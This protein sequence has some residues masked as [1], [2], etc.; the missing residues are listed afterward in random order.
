MK[1]LLFVFG[2]VFLLAGCAAP[3]KVETH[4]PLISSIPPQYFEAVYADLVIAEAFVEHGEYLWAYLQYRKIFAET[5]DEVAFFYYLA[6]AAAEQAGS[7]HVV[8][9]HSKF[10]LERYQETKF[11]LPVFYLDRVKEMFNRA[12]LIEEAS[13]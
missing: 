2:M 11:P 9:R 10:L 4:L 12:A 5:N 1:N 3:Q 6:I 8:Y 7:N 13:K